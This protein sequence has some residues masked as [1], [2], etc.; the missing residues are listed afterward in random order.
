MTKPTIYHCE[1]RSDTQGLERGHWFFHTGQWALCGEVGRCDD[2]LWRLQVYFEKAGKSL[3]STIPSFTTLRESV[4]WLEDYFDASVQRV[5]AS[6]MP[7]PDD[8]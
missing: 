2:G 5:R 7:R 3:P 4:R 6:Q 8:L 1:V